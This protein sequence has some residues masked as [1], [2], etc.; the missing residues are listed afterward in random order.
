MM[1]TGGVLFVDIVLGMSGGVDSSV[2]AYL[3]QRAGHRVHGVTLHMT[4]GAP[5]NIEGAQAVAERLGISFAV[6]DCRTSFHREVEQYFADAYRRGETPNPCVICNAVVKLQAL[7]AY[8]EEHSYDGFATGHYAKIGLD[9]N[10]KRTLLRAVDLQKDQSYMLYRITGEQL[11][12]M[13]LPLGDYTKPE[14]RSIAEKQQL[15]P[16]IPRDSMDICFVPDGNYGGYLQRDHQMQPCKGAFLDANGAVIGH[17][18]GQWLYTVGQRKGLGLSCGQPVYVISKDAQENTVTVGNE[19]E[20]FASVCH[21]RDCNLLMTEKETVRGT[22]KVR[23]S[24]T[25]SPVTANFSADGTATLIFDTPQRAMTCGQSAVV[26][27]GDSVIGG[28]IICGVESGV[29]K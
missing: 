26:Y 29:E 18:C 10:H 13:Y 2:A 7:L 12:R 3:L 17:H 20:L 15:M 27:D 4:D 11:A 6:V 22:A 5:P 19:T 21:L 24:R 1:K 23:Y 8:A 14:I 16:S 9:I 25:E 28:G